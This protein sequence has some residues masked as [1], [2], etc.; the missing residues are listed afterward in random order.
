MQR[1][2]AFLECV[3]R[4]GADIAKDDTD[5]RKHQKVSRTMLHLTRFHRNRF[6]DA[7]LRVL[8]IANCHVARKLDCVKRLFY[9]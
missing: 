7:G 5:R 1:T 8:R 6:K 4:A 2:K 3:K 9:Q